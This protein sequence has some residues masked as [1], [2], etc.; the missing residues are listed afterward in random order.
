LHFVALCAYTGGMDVNELIGG[1]AAG[2]LLA[3]A[4]LWC[5]KH[6]DTKED[7][8]HPPWWAIL[9]GI[10]ILGYIGLSITDFEKLPLRD[11][12]GAASHQATCI[13]ESRIARRTGMLV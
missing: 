10:A 6:L 2:I 5:L 12:P 8:G 13:K 11:Q 9:G 4:F 7:D 3:V 1:V